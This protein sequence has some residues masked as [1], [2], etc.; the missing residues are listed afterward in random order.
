MNESFAL[1]FME[2]NTL[3][4]VTRV[5]PDLG[6]IIAREDDGWPRR[7]E[8]T[9]V[10][11]SAGTIFRMKDFAH[12]QEWD[13]PL[14]K[15]N[16]QVAGGELIFSGVKKNGLPPGDYELTVDVEDLPVAGSR[17][18][19]IIP[20]GGRATLTLPVHVDPRQIKLNQSVPKEINDVIDAST[21]DGM[22]GRTWLA[23]TTRRVQRKACLLNLLAKLS[24]IPSWDAGAVR[25]IRRVDSIFYARTERVYAAVQPG[26]YEDV[27]SFVD[28]EQHFYF[29]GA[30]AA[31]IHQDLFK[32][33]KLQV[34]KYKAL[35]FRQEGRPSMQAVIAQPIGDGKYYTD[36]DIDLGNPLQ[37][38][39]GISIHITELLSGKPTDH[40]KLW[41]TLSKDP[42][43]APYMCYTI[44]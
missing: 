39:E 11:H 12:Q 37:D 4:P 19:L 25:L 30:P 44:V 15:L 3:W 38:V 2:N 24:S 34:K 43:T 36:L 28:A 41:E 13:Y 16:A 40:V 10:P 21:I 32:A 33:K 31:S 18:P 5:D 7:C 29:E 35:S 6:V 26:F 8:L 27:R 23:D 9:L 17:F 1:R 42:S 20:E 14:Y 22:P